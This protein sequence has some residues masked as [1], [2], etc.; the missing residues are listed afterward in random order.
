MSPTEAVLA[1]VIEMFCGAAGALAVRWSWPNP[2]FNKITAVLAGMVGG[3]A[4]TYVAARIPGVGHF[5]GHVESTAD[6]IIRGVGGLTPAVLVGIGV[7][8]V[9]G[10]I[11]L[12]VIVGFIR[13][14]IGT[15]R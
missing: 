2:G 13:N 12:T 8:G 5:V 10:G 3:L 9:L 14:V 7:S 1:I 11:I 15:G 4:M 6:S